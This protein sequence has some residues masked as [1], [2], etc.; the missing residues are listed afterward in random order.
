MLQRTAHLAVDRPGITLWTFVAVTCAFAI[1]GSAL[2][3]RY[4]GQRFPTTASSHGGS[5]ILYLA[6]GVGETAGRELSA[7]LRGLPGVEH[8]ELVTA[9]ES[10]NRL[11][12][13]LGA[14]A[15]LLEGVDLATIPASIEAALSPGV[16]DVITMSPTLKALR[17]IP[18]VVDVVVE[19]GGG[20]AQRGAVMSLRSAL[21]AQTTV[22]AVLALVIAIAAMRVWLEP[23]PAAHRVFDLLGAPPGF[24]AGPTLLAGVLFGSAAALCSA[25]AVGLAIVRYGEAMDAA[26]PSWVASLGFVGIGA[27]AGAVAAGLAGVFRASS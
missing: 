13:A 19:G 22:M 6:D 3:M 14:D 21:D 15:A 17:D 18:G 2:A 26:W 8:A 5:M 1:A 27:A 10:A 12:Q 23:D 16:R 24:A 20:N 4:G 7:R 9:S 11:V 25:I